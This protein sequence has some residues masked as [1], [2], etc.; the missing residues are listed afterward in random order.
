ML[1]FDKK[2]KSSAVDIVYSTTLFQFAAA[3]TK[4]NSNFKML[5]ASVFDNQL[6]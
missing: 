1:R 6:E 2:I 3:L 4:S 5:I